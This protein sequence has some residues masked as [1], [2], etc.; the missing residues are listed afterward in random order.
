VLRTT[1]VEQKKATSPA[2]KLKKS[3][4]AP[5]GNSKGAGNKATGKIK[6]ATIRNAALSNRRVKASQR[7]KRK[8]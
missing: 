1:L 7:S 3:A 2:A 4:D 5:S 8:V 6:I